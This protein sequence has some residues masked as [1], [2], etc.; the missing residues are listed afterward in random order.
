MVPD[1]LTT[2]HKEPEPVYN[3]RSTGRWEYFR[4]YTCST[5][6]D[7]FDIDV[8]RLITLFYHIQ[9]L[10]TSTLCSALKQL[11]Q[12]ARLEAS[13]TSQLVANYTCE[14]K[15]GYGVPG[16][17]YNIRRYPENEITLLAVE[18]GLYELC[19]PRRSND[20][21]LETMLHRIQEELLTGWFSKHYLVVKGMP[22]FDKQLRSLAICLARGT[23]ANSP[24]LVRGSHLPVSVW[25]NLVWHSIV[26]LT[27]RAS[28][29]PVW[30]L[31][32]LH[33]ADKDFTL[34][35][36][37]TCNFS[38]V[39]RSGKLVSVTGHW[40]LDRRQFHSAIYIPED[41]GGILKLAKSR[42]WS[43]S[44]MELVCFW[45]PLHA[46]KFQTIHELSEND[47][48]LSEQNLQNLMQKFGFDL[49][50][51]TTQLWDIPEPLF[52][53]W[54]GTSRLLRIPEYR[55]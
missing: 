4:V 34:N 51:W 41:H 15:Q 28:V 9:N 33:G 47:A 52:R 8:R 55:S 3:S 30:L 24:I 19:P 29:V 17:T 26:T 18:H 35:F 12:L 53:T 16:P 13:T 46:E 31:F 5:T 39:D 50:C 42:N 7:F 2:S 11:K 48:G 40:G 21:L 25:Q 37:Q 49:T 14:W 36:E 27:L 6:Y 32:L 45:F 10:D 38:E 54:E 23:P 44:L 20:V 43:L 1:V 22:P